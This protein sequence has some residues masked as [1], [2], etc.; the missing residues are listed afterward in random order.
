MSKAKKAPKKRPKKAKSPVEPKQ[1]LTGRTLRRVLRKPRKAVSLPGASVKVRGR[2]KVEVLDASTKNVV[3]GSGWISNLILNSGIDRLFDGERFRDQLTYAVAGEGTGVSK[4]EPIGTYSQSGT[5]ALRIT[6]ARDFTGADVGRT[7]YW[8]TSE[9]ATIVSITDVDEVEVNRSQTIAV[10]GAV[11]LYYTEREGLEAEDERTNTY[12]IYTDPDAVTLSCDNIADEDDAT[13]LFR[14]TFDFTERVTPITYGEIGFSSQG[15]SGDNLWARVHLPG[16][17]EIAD[18]QQ[19]RIRYEL[20][21]K[22]GSALDGDQVVGEFPIDGWPV[23]YAING[24]VSNGTTW[25]ITTDGDHHH[26][27]GATVN[28]DGT[29]DYDGTGY[30]V[31]STT[32]TTIVVINSNN[33]TD[34]GTGGTVFSDTIARQHQL[35]YGIANF[36]AATAGYNSDYNNLTGVGDLAPVLEPS[37][38]GVAGTERAY[39]LFLISSDPIGSWP[40]EGGQDLAGR[41]SSNNVELAPQGYTIGNHYEGYEA[42]FRSDDAIGDDVDCI[43]LSSAAD[44]DPTNHVTGAVPA[45]VVWKFEQTHVKDDLHR[46]VVRLKLSVERDFSINP[47]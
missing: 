5:T 7:L 23:E 43:G 32:S 24:I 30:I 39:N 25:V 37:R 11:K 41:T 34:A 46:L 31:D 10:A 22:C 17:V 20:L 36:S 8:A 12:A 3:R 28:I 26:V 9:Q 42:I 4:E 35:W 1:L 14:R 18:G 6:G 16:G 47:E 29:V 33:H 44:N 27:D 13:V 38:K 2:I 40:Q 21:V 19:L 15:G 45:Q